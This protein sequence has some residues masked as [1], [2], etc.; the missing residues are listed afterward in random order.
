MYIAQRRLLMSKG[1]KPVH[2]NL[3]YTNGEYICRLYI[4]WSLPRLYTAVTSDFLISAYASWYYNGNIYT[5]P[6]AVSKRNTD[7]IYFDND[8]TTVYAVNAIT[9]HGKDWYWAIGGGV[10]GNQSS[11]Q[12]VV[13]AYKINNAVGG[14]YPEG[15][16]RN[17]IA[18]DILD[19]YYG[20]IG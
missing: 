3:E 19:Y 9:Y 13:G 4:N 10:S 12:P 15:Y 11:A 1:L 16:S 8:P 17:D 20:L 14:V 5:A 6:F 18:R 7:G 2:R